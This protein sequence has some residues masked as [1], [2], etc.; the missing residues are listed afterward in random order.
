[1]IY[2]WR[3][4]SRISIY[5]LCF[6][7]FL[8]LSFSLHRCVCVCCCLQNMPFCCRLRFVSIFSIVRSLRFYGSVDME[9]SGI[10]CVLGNFANR[11]GRFVSYTHRCEHKPRLFC[12]SV[13]GMRFRA[14][15]GVAP[16][17]CAER[18]DA[19]R[20]EATQSDATEL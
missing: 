18:C 20:R 6:F 14:V 1:M 10:T 3:T 11:F 17:R 12:A 15:R 4:S 9:K 8:P 16:R 2:R 5:P 7:F 19:R 13:G